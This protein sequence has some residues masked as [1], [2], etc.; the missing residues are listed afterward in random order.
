MTIRIL[1]CTLRDGGYHNDWDFSEELIDEYLAVMASSK[2]DFV[3]LGF[4]QFSSNKFLGATA[5]TTNRYLKRKKLP[6][7]PSFGVMVDAK[8]LIQTKLSP[9]NSIKA[10]FDSA[11]KE[12]IN[13]VRVAAHFH[14]VFQIKDSFKT[15]N[16]L[17]YKVG[18][19]LM[20]VSEQ[21]LDL[22][23]KTIKEISKWEFIDFLYFAD[24]LGSMNGE[25][26]INVYERFKE[27]W[28]KD[29]GFHAHNNKGLAIENIR[30]AINVGC[31]MIDSTVT[32]MGRGAGNGETEFLLNDQCFEKKNVKTSRLVSLASKYFLPLKK[33]YGWGASSDYLMG[34]ELGLHPTYIQELRADKNCTEKMRIKIIKDLGKM[35]SPSNFSKENL[36]AVKSSLLSS[37]RSARGIEFKKFLIKKEV[38]IIAQTESVIKYENAIL[39]YIEE[40]N[41]VVISINH[42]LENL[43]IPYDLVAISHN[44]KYREEVKKYSKGKF[45]YLAPSDF[46]ENL[47]DSFKKK[48]KFNYGIEIKNGKFNFYKDYCVVPYPMT[49]AYT[50]AFVKQAGSENIKLIGFDGHKE[51]DIR[52]KNMQNFFQIAS[53][54][55]INLVSLTPTNYALEEKSLHD[56][57]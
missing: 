44:E 21:P 28:K 14:E 41:P 13:F 1:D 23:S 54:K 42:P 40:K 17:G 51:G 35:D 24:S 11:K 38:L 4:R 2:I 48:I 3:E 56:Y 10:L 7:G 57:F 36:Q 27:H 16:K 6:N 45:A 43:S 22:I 18:L 33:Q 5:F 8:T 32:G 37:Q 15:L 30:K 25:D 49:L 20:Q 31:T 19:N 46:F 53:K 52:Q 47:N 50:I 29:I 26:L 12:K 39:D 9:S 34:A 55:N